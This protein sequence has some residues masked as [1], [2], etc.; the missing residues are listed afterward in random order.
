[1][2]D[3]GEI[4]RENLITIIDRH[5]EGV[6]TLLARAMG[7][8]PNQISRYVNGT[9]KIG[10][11]VARKIE[12][13]T[14][15]SRNWLDIDHD[16]MI[17]PEESAADVGD[18]GLIASANLKKWM[19]HNSQLSTQGKLSRACGITQPTIGRFLNAESSVSIRNLDVIAKAFNRQGYELLIAPNDPEIIHYDKRG[20]A[21]LSDEDKKTIEEFIQFMIDKNKK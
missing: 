6:Q 3:L 4:R 21:T 14:R 13:V 5:Y 19:M 9:K 11:K 7:Y 16:Q 12:E 15:H 1:M 2:K 8:Q 18:I 20:Y 10:E 17:M